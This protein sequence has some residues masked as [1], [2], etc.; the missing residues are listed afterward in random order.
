[1]ARKPRD[2]EP[3]PYYKW[4]WRDWRGSRLVQRMTA[5]QR[6]IYRELLDEQWKSGALLNDP[7]WLAEAAMCTVAELADAWQVLSICFPEVPDSDGRLLANPRLEAERTETDRLRV[8]RANAGR[9]GGKANA[10]QVSYSSS[11]A[12]QSS[13]NGANG[14]V[15]APRLGDA[16][17][18]S[19]DELVGPEA[20]RAILDDLKAKRIP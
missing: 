1:M 18:P 13:S 2:G 15:A 19:P 14:R 9:I 6:G 7:E 17:A 3:L 4:Y 5:L 20:I 16:A 11:R 8:V 10:K 12:E